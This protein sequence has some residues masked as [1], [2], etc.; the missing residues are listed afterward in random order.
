MKKYVCL[1]CGC[2]HNGDEPRQPVLSAALGADKFKD[3]GE[4]AGCC[5][6]SCQVCLP[7]AWADEHRVELPRD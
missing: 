2:V 3:M 4:A 1:I 5:G 7:M 6:I